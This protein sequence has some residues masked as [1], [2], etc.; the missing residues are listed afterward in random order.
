[1]GCLPPP[2]LYLHLQPL[3]FPLW[4]DTEHIP[5][6]HHYFSQTVT[7]FATKASLRWKKEACMDSCPRNVMGSIL[8]HKTHSHTQFGTHRSSICIITNT[9]ELY[10]SQL[11]LA[12]EWFP[13][14]AQSSDNKSSW[15]TPFNHL[16]WR[17]CIRQTDEQHKTTRRDGPDIYRCVLSMPFTLRKLGEKN[18]NKDTTAESSRQLVIPFISALWWVLQLKGPQMDRVWPCFELFQ[19][20]QEVMWLLS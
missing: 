8:T 11:L 9:L 14:T 7:G 15:W 3:S 4:A 10:W 6:P 17:T 19:Q 2:S 20:S 5:E 18:R 16:H 12:V 1:M 13:P